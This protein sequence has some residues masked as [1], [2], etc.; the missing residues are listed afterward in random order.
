M[1]AALEKMMFDNV[2]IIHFIGIGGIGMSGIAE[3]MHNLGH[4][5]QGSDLNENDNVL[6]LRNLGIKVFIGNQGENIKGASVV[7]RSTA[8]KEDNPEV[9]AARGSRIP[10]VK[11]SEMLAELMRLKISIAI[12]GAHGK[13]TTT[14]LVAAMLESAELS[15]T[16]IN[17]GIINTRETNA[18]LGSSDYLVAEADES[19][20]TFIR[21]PS[22][23]AVITNIDPEHLDYYGSF[24]NLKIAYETFIHNLP[25]YGFAVAC[26]DH[27]EVANL[28]QKIQD[29]EII[30]YGI[31]SDQLDVRAINIKENISSTIFDVKVSSR[32][33]EKEFVLEKIILPLAGKHNVLNALAAISIGIK[34][35]FKPKQ[36]SN[37]FTNFKGVKRRFTKTGEVNC[38]TI[39][40][41]YAHHPEEIKATLRTAKQVTRD[42]K[43]SKIIAIAQLHRYTRVEN[44]FSDF[45][46][47]FDD[48]DIVFISDIY[49]AGEKPIEGINKEVMISALKQNYKNKKIFSLESPD[50]LPEMLSNI[51]SKEDLVIFM[52]AGT[53][54]KWA[55]DLPAAWEKYLMDKQIRSSVKCIKN[56]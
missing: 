54:T 41:D 35:K 18:Y 56:D 28:I 14:A 24:E 12:S 23:I 32:I 4:Q 52:G 19:D 33:T 2:G 49:S 1:R 21:I 11:R 31:D 39:I 30:T 10:V 26:K 29:R 17:G 15:P 46:H 38:I 13:T 45:V 34:L 36:I 43:D 22:T 40:D 3:I 25:F 27:H 37:A 42:T 6:R 16:V 55:Y 53:S 51:A 5:I 50:S 47:C 9:V 44:L 7:V 48:A 20:G 8:V